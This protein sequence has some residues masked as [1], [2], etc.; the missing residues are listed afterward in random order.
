MDVE[1]ESKKIV[2][3]RPGRN[4]GMVTG[5]ERD[6]C[7]EKGLVAGDCAGAVRSAVVDDVH[8]GARDPARCENAV[9]PREGGGGVPLDGGDP[10]GFTGGPGQDVPGHPR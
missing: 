10:D 5:E 6:D 9:G 4:P 2:P 3:E 7:E 1:V 8:G